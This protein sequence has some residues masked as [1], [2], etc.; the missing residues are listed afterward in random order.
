MLQG[1]RHGP[2]LFD[3][4]TPGDPLDD[5]QDQ[6]VVADDPGID[7]GGLLCQMRDRSAL[8]PF[9]QPAHLSYPRIGVGLGEQTVQSLNQ[10]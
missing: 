4:I 3:A 1:L 5:A 9:V 2:G 10:S 6:G 7:F 8:P